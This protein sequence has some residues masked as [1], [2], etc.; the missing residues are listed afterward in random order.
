MRIKIFNQEFEIIERD[1]WSDTGM[2]M[3]N[4]KTGEIWLYKGL[5]D[6]IKLS[7]L[8]HEIIHLI[9]DNMGLNACIEDDKKLE[10][11]V[12]GLATGLFHVLRSNPGIAKG[13]INEM[14]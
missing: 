5:K 7:T 4:S 1:S 10:Q 14:G 12:T 9:M 2:G 11:I 3:S 8:L 6:D 13:I